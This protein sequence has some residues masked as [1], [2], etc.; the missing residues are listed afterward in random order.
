MIPEE[1]T[2]MGFR[3]SVFNIV[4]NQLHMTNV[5]ECLV[6]QL[7]TPVQKQ[8]QM[9][10]AK[11]ILQLCQDEKVEFFNRLITMDEFWVYH[12]VPE[13]KEM[14]KQWKHADS[15]PPEKAKCQPLL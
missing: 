1:E 11:E 12:Y 5:A 8:K 6:P 3:E 2:S 14:I 4:H 7:L 13:T 15:L 10:A 9:D